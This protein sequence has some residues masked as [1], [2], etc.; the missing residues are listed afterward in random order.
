[1][2]RFDSFASEWDMAEHGQRLRL[3]PF[4]VLAVIGGVG[5]YGAYLVIT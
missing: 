5:A 1:M 3:W 2:T 4:L